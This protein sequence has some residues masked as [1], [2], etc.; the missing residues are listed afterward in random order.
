MY[1]TNRLYTQLM[2]TSK[3]SDEIASGC[4][5]ARARGLARSVT[6]VYE[7]HLRPLG[8]KS[9]QQT[10]L[11]AIA[12]G[13]HRPVEIGETLHMEKSTVARALRLMESNGWVTLDPVGAGRHVVLSTAGEELLAAS[14]K[15]WRAAT[16]EIA[17]RLRDGDGL[18]PYLADESNNTPTDWK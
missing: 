8:L 5:A 16:R 6:R 10:V 1:A 15:P 14:L 18:L 13:A 2:T 17:E 12:Q 4:Y 9:S 3:I 11:T 7:D